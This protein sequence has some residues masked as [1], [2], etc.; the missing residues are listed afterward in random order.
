MK[1]KTL[2]IQIEFAYIPNFQSLESPPIL[3]PLNLV[4]DQAYNISF[5]ES[6]RF[7]LKL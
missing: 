5:R 6:F 4:L 1:K 2:V 3:F 7:T